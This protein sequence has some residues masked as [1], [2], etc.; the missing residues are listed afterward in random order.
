MYERPGEVGKAGR[1]HQ[2]FLVFNARPAPPVPVFREL[3]LDHQ[4]LL[5]EHQ[6]RHALLGRQDTEEVLR[7]E[8]VV[9][10]G[11]QRHPHPVRTAE[12]NVEVV[13][14]DDEDA[15]RRI[16]GELE[17]FALR[18]GIPALADRVV[19][20]KPNE[21]ERFDLLRNAVLEDLEVVRRQPLDDLAVS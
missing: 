1:E 11:N 8:D 3:F 20:R 21:L 15:V 5:A 12:I 2:V 19:L 4:G 17:A 13:K 16:G 14:I 10:E 9:Q 6:I 18:V 7:S